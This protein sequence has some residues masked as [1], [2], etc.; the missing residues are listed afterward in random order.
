VLEPIVSLEPG[1]VVDDRYEII[2]PIS[3]GAT[4][5]TY[6]A[7]DRRLG[8]AI[9]LRTLRPALAA[10]PDVVTKFRRAAGAFGAV[11][12]P[13]IVTMFDYGVDGDLCYLSTEFVDG[14]SVA[15]EVRAN[16]AL[17]AELAVGA[18][19]DVASALDTVHRAGLLHGGLEP[20]D[21]FLRKTGVAK[22]TDFGTNGP[23]L[24]AVQPGT[25]A[26]TAMY[27]S[28]EQARGEAAGVRSDLYA[29]GLVFYE[30]LT[31]AAAFAGTDAQEI[32][33]RQVAEL[34]R[35]PSQLVSPLPFG[36]DV[37]A[38][39]LLAKH[40][41]DRYQSAAEV[42]ND[43]RGLRDTIRPPLSSGPTHF[44]EERYT[45]MVN[46]GAATPGD[47]TLAITMP[48]ASRAPAA[49]AGASASS[50]SASSGRGWLW[51]A[52]TIVIVALFVGVLVIAMNGSG[53]SKSKPNP[54][55]KPT[56][57]VTVPNVVGRQELDATTRLE[58]LGFQV[59]ATQQANFDIPAGQVFDQSPNGGT[60]GNKGDAVVLTVSSGAQTT[61]TGATTTTDTT[62]T[63]STTS[64]TSS[65]PA[66]TTAATTT[67]PPT[68]AASATSAPTTST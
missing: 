9:A 49:S 28:P 29:L 66:T 33:K 26:D 16:G 55:P 1:A 60:K 44:T 22:V 57:A 56:Q 2:R 31:G 23:A 27:L 39:R 34:P 36:C 45:E 37:I 51:A 25:A 11:R 38:M 65:A 40:P 15:D 52:A 21:V 24:G 5:E 13:E 48:P 63:A 18:A 61:T 62:T 32:A 12:G 68:T 30:M 14:R 50:G 7:T 47:A 46:L 58:N 54:N 20:S 41:E 17:K 35:P 10:N 19:L 53:S 43:L 6:L 4:S 64:T 67:A 59:S 3:S 42:M 8:R